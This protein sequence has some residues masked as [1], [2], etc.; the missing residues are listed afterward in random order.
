MIVAA[1]VLGFIAL[2]PVTASRYPA[3][4]ASLYDTRWPVSNSATVD[5][6]Q[7]SPFGPRLKTSEDLR[8]DWHRG[9][10]ALNCTV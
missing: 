6:R 1:A 10:S 9:V 3:N 7:S 5:L 2:T 4:I 8:Y